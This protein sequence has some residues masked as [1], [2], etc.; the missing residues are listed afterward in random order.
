MKPAIV[1]IKTSIPSTA[2][3][4]DHAVD[5][6]TRQEGRSQRTAC[7]TKEGSG[8]VDDLIPRSLSP[9]ARAPSVAQVIAAAAELGV[10][11]TRFAAYAVWRWG[12]G[13]RRHAADRAHAL[14]EIL[15]YRN[16]A[17]GFCDK[18]DTA[19][20]RVARKPGKGNMS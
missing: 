1:S 6:S 12:G 3:R 14:D 4:A 8:T 17:E 7:C 13:W 18:V 19:W 20:V 2:C 10:N 9:T 11:A 5:V 15:R 16:D